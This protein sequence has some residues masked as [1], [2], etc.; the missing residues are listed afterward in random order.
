MVIPTQYVDPSDC[1]GGVPFPT[2]GAPPWTRFRP[3]C[4]P[5]GGLNGFT[6]KQL[7]E[8]RKCAILKY[9]GVRSGRAMTTV[10]DV[11]TRK[12]R[13]VRAV[14]GQY[15]PHMSFAQQTQTTTNPNTKSWVV[16]DDRKL[17]YENDD[18]SSVEC[19]APCQP[20]TASDVPSSPTTQCL[21]DVSGVP[22]TRF[23]PQRTYSN[24]VDDFLDG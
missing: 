21:I 2:P 7:D 10:A 19:A 6:T 12:Q 8:K 3:S 23:H 22:L 14:R 20:L 4:I 9:K 16:V 11:S 5:L 17:L 18:G 15:L 13:Y 1:S 24:G